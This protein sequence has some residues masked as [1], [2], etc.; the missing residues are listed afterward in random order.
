MTGKSERT[1]RRFLKANVEDHPEYF[2]M[3]TRNGRDVWLIDAAFLKRHYPFVNA[4]KNDTVTSSVNAGQ[5]THDNKALQRTWQE[6][7]QELRDKKRQ[8]WTDEAATDRTNDNGKPD[9]PAGIH[10]E[11]QRLW[12]LVSDLQEQVAKKDQQLDRYFTEQGELMKTMGRLMEQDNLLLARSQEATIP[13]ATERGTSEPMD[14][15]PAV[16]VEKSTSEKTKPTTK[17]K[18]STQKKKVVKAKTVGPKKPWWRFG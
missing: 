12:K 17:K 10:E 4:G 15:K 13:V 9:K 1:I 2:E 8:E 7:R 18:S 3:E 16:V 11:N 5:M 14:V 6:K